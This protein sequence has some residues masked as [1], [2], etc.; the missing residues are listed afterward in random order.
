MEQKQHNPSYVLLLGGIAVVSF[1]GIFVLLYHL[2]VSAPA[3]PVLVATMPVKA[4]R[5]LTI[6]ED[7]ATY[8][9]TLYVLAADNTVYACNYDYRKS[10]LCIPGQLPVPHIGWPLATPIDPVRFITSEPV[11]D[12]LSL[13]RPEPDATMSVQLN[14]TAS[15]EIW[16]LTTIVS[17]YTVL[18]FVPVSAVISL[19]SSIVIVIII[20]RLLKRRQ[21][22][23]SSIADPAPSDSQ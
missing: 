5:M 19:V 9:E 6:E 17:A 20:N 4:A 8:K 15:G 16:D 14:L 1:I 18:F 7:Y 13:D 12:I 11:I 22:R 10:S 23:M 2:L 21:R 3:T